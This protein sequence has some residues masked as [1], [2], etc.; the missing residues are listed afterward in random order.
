MEMAW[1]RTAGGSTDVE[2]DVDALRVELFL[3]H[4][5]GSGDGR[6][7]VVVLGRTKIG[8]VSHRS[9]RDDH[10]VADGVR[11]EIEH[12]EHLGASVQNQGLSIGQTRIQDVG[13]DVSAGDGCV[14]RGSFEF[15]EVA[16]TPAGPQT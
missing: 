16:M 13:K 7:E 5:D 2:T 10:L 14:G 9:V 4:T 1:N 6:P 12:D 3:H 8:Q 11:M 15:G